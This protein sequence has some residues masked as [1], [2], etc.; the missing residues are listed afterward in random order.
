MS[1][2]F[3]QRE[4]VISNESS[5][6]WISQSSDLL[7]RFW[8]S[9]FCTTTVFFM[10]WQ[11]NDEIRN[12]QE[13]S[14]CKYLLLVVGHSPISLVNLPHP[15]TWLLPHTV[16]QTL[17]SLLH[18]ITQ[19]CKIKMCTNFPFIYFILNFLNSLNFIW[20]IFHCT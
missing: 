12:F 3:F 11:T 18:C 10:L 17:F 20:L 14:V 8:L 5:S 13:S 2:F 6:V 1:T 15:S 7:F 4:T 19:F 16:S 9:H